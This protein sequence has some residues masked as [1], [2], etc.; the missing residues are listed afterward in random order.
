MHY[1][2]K[3]PVR[4]PAQAKVID[5]TSFEV[6]GAVIKDTILSNVSGL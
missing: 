3:Q 4:L 6:T 2:I 1:D 5:L